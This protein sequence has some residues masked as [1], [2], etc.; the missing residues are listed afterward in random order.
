MSTPSNV[1]SG[2]PCVI[3]E[4]QHNWGTL[5]RRKTPIESGTD[6]YITR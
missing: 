4:F 5:G 2:L 3:V 1:S 6:V